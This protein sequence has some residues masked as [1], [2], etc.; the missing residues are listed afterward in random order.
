MILLLGGPLGLT[1]EVPGSPAV[2]G[3]PWGWPWGCLTANREDVF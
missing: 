3:I 2:A 1:M